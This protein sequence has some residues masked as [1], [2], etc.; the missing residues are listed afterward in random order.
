MAN[1]RSA[2]KRNRQNKKRRARNRIFR[3]R[4]RTFVKQANEAIEAGNAEQAQE[5]VTL[6]AAALDRAA[7]KGVIHK[8]N[9]ARRKSAVMRK[10]A[11]MQK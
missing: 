6:A 2:I 1:I 4:A 11:A 10:L 3:G 8:N 5:A 9:A 7:S